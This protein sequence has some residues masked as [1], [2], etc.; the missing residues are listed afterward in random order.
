MKERCGEKRL[1]HSLRLRNSARYE[2][3]ARIAKEDA[4][5]IMDLANSLHKLLGQE[6]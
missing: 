3:H 2:P 5:K 6:L 1:W 4:E